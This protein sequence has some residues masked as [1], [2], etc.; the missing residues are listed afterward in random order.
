MTSARGYVELHEL[1]PGARFRF[2]AFPDQ[3]ATLVAKTLGRALVRYDRTPATDTRTFEAR[4]PRTG[5]KVTKMIA[6]THASTI[7]PCALGA[8][9]VPLMAPEAGA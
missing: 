4:D 1:A 2:L 3:V 7:E 6:V 9:V 8:Q 5:E